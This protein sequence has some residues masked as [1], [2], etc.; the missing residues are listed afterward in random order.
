MGLTEM[1]AIEI[2]VIELV[3]LGFVFAFLAG[4]FL[5][6]QYTKVVSKPTHNKQNVAQG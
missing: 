5:G 3:M 4:W 1:D 2:V 6:R